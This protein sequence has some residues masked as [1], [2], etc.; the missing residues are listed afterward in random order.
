MD[1]TD[2]I[3]GRIVKTDLPRPTTAPRLHF[4][5]PPQAADTVTPPPSITPAQNRY[6]PR[7]Q[8]RT[9]IA[10]QSSTHLI[11]ESI[12]YQV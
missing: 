2:E 7:L 8:L 9:G 4:R 3:K 5:A 12:V 6:P 1:G 11:F 10:K